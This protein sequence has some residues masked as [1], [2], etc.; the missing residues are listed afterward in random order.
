MIICFECSQLTKKVLDELLNRG[1]YADYS[2]AISAA[3][4]NLGVLHR[5]IDGKG[6]L[7]IDTQQSVKQTSLTEVMENGLKNDLFVSSGKPI[8]KKAHVVVPGLFQNKDLNRPSHF[9]PLPEDMWSFNDNIPLNKWIFAMCNRLLPA[10]SNCRALAHMQMDS[11]GSVLYKQARSEI[12]SVAARLGDFLR[13]YDSRN[14]LNRDDAFA[15]AFPISGKGNEKSLERYLNQF[16]GYVNKEGY[17]DS[18]LY[19]LKLINY[20]SS[21]NPKIMLTEAGWDIALLDNP[22][23]DN[24][25]S[26]YEKKLSDEEI[27]YLLEHIAHKVPV[28]DYAYRTIIRLIINGNSAPSGLDKSLKSTVK[29]EKDTKLTDSFLSSQRS[30]AVSRMSDLDLIKRIRTGVAIKYELTDRAHRYIETRGH[31]N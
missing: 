3:I 19:S 31:E 26:D 5:E 7:I 29:V 1:E 13:D 15:T 2:Q 30:G 25:D 16:L 17:V 23:L 22:I 28:E 12:S 4:E 20:E 21:K 24:G 9:A 14:N 6:S 8:L 18:L 27:D 10:I 11:G